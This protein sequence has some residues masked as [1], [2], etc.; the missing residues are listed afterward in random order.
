MTGDAGFSRHTH[1]HTNQPGFLKL[2][3][4]HIQM[5]RLILRYAHAVISLSE[6]QYL[7]TS[8]SLHLVRVHINRISYNTPQVSV[9]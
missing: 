3:I 8:T 1:A 4:C 7:V 9:L 5:S 2:S 6:L